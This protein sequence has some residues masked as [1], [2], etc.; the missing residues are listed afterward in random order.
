[1]KLRGLLVAFTISTYAAGAEPGADSIQQKSASPKDPAAVAFVVGGIVPKEAP[2]RPLSGEERWRLFLNENFAF[3]GGAYFR[4]FGAA[5]PDHLNNRPEDW[6]Q[7]SQ[8][9]FTRVGDRFVRFTLSTAFEHA[10]AAAA[11]LD[12]RYVRSKDD[13]LLRRFAH[14][15]QLAVLTYDREGNK[16]FY[17]SRFA[18]AF[19]GEAISAAWNPA[20][21]WEVR[22]YQ[23]AAQQVAAAWLFNMIREFS[24][25]IKRLFV[26]RK[27]Q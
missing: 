2:Y 14:A 15:S 17:W 26:G 9:Y 5:L 8:G 7:G 21:R 22:G 12:P 19:A 24:P 3:K 23:G 25:D 13:G 11:G 16:T 1:M 10:G 18:G 6:G 27:R 4:A 20:V